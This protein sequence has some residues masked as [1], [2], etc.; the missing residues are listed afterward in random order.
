MLIVKADCP[1]LLKVKVEV[2]KSISY[3]FYMFITK[4][5]VPTGGQLY[6]QCIP[7]G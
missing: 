4:F 2:A 1:K 6:A 7:W 5:V 3:E